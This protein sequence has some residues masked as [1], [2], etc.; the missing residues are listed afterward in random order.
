MG[1]DKDRLSCKFQIFQYLF[2]FY[3]SL[4]QDRKLAH[5]RSVS[6]DRGSMPLPDKGAASCLLKDRLHKSQVFHS[7][8]PAPKGQYSV[9]SP[10]DHLY[11][12]R[13]QKT[14]ILAYCQIIIY[15]EKIRYITDTGVQ[16]IRIFQSIFPVNDH[17]S[18]FCL[19]K[20]CYDFDGCCLSCSVWPNKSIKGTFLTVMF[21]PLK[22]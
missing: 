10:P 4:D 16:L 1:T 19:Q 6:V 3:V 17:T 7:V 21:R 20:T 14:H 8:P 13:Q 22:A 5:L 15:T 11:G 12:S 18:F 2:K 9:F